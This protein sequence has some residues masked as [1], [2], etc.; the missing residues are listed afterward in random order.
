MNRLK[1]K[2][3]AFMYGRYGVDEFGRFLMG[4]ALGLLI[5]TI[6]I[7]IPMLYYFA[8]AV[9]V[10]AYF[11]ILSK[12]RSKRYEENRA[13]ANLRYKMVC[14]KQTVVNRMKDSRTHRIFKCPNCCQKIRVP[15]GKGKIC[16][17][18]PKCRIEFIKKT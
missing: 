6:F 2:L 15:K 16:I 14:R 7:R 4:V 18:C 13:Y 1:A 10:Y 11:R 17:K 9:L 5:I 12:N 8:L 3:T